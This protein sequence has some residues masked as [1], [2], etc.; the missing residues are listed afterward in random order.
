MKNVF[1]FLGLEELIIKNKIDKIV[2]SHSCD[3]YSVISYDL[4]EV[5]LSVAIQDALTPPF[6]SPSKVIIL[7]NPLFLTSTKIEM[8]H[9][10]QLLLSYLEAPSPTTILIIDATGLTLDEKKDVVKRLLKEAEVSD[11]KELTAVEAEGWLKRQFAI[12]GLDIKEDAVKL[13]FSRI[14]KNL[15]NAKN[16]VD[17]LLN[18][19]APRTVVTTKDIMDVVTKEAESEVY[20]LTNSIIDKNKEKTMNIY[21]ELTK[22]GKDSV[23]LLG[24]VSRSMMDMFIVAL[25][26]EKGYKQQ[27]VADALKISSGRAYYLVRNARAFKISVVEENI[28]KLS[29]LDYKIKSGQIDATSGLELFLFGL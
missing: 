27:E 7:R 24:L 17:K 21:H 19:I 18:Y 8:K 4:E 25:M 22:N 20:S 26:L 12:E 13:F 29:S 2:R 16:E 10:P 9:N 3:E 28:R 14:G 11:T 6:I 5:N 23:Q 1:L 15:L